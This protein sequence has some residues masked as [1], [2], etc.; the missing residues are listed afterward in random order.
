MK[1]R[2]LLV[3][4]FAIFTVLLSACG[5]DEKA[6]PKQQFTFG[7]QTISLEGANIFIDYNGTFNETHIYR[8]YFITDG[9]ANGNGS[10]YYIEFELAVPEGEEITEGE[11]PAFYNWS[12]AEG[13]SN[14]SYL[15]AESGEDEQYVEIDL[16]EDADGSDKIVVSGGV[17]DGETM[18][19]KFKGNVAYYHFD[20]TNWITETVSGK[21]YAKGEVDD[22]SSVPTRRRKTIPGGA[23]KQAQ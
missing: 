7:D 6:K 14:I 9:D 23:G 20:G 12:S 10:T 22:I 21:F 5:D 1:I 18:T 15:Y 13:T 3:Y 2:K 4:T 17:G 8:D 11:Y 19:V 16:L